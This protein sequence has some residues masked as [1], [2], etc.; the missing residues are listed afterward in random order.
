MH[1]IDKEITR[2]LV[3]QFYYI[4]VV[5]SLQVVDYEHNLVIEYNKC[6]TLFGVMYLGH[7]CHTTVLVQETWHFLKVKDTSLRG[8][9][10]VNKQQ[11][12]KQNV[13]IHGQ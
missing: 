5:F 11:N 3:F 10:F 9:V 8:Q 6:P 13:Y 12:E 4:T 7:K 1:N 2:E